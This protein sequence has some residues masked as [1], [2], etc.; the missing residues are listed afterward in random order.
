MG[1]YVHFGDLCKFTIS[2]V[3]GNHSHT[4]ENEQVQKL[5]LLLNAD[6]ETNFC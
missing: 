2:E 5:S 3:L 6:H 4:A 1:T